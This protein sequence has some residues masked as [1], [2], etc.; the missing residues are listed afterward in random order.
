MGVFAT[1]YVMHQY[2]EWLLGTV[3]NILDDTLSVSSAGLLRGGAVAWVEVSVPESIT[4]PEGVTF[5]PNLLA[6]TSFDGSIATTFKRTVTDTV[7]DN[8]RG[9]ALAEKGQ[10]YRVKH[11]RHSR[12]RLAE[13][14]D[15]LALVHTMAED[16]AAEITTLASTSVSS[17]QWNQFLDQQ[18]LTT[19]PDGQP[20]AG[21][22][23]T[24]A[25]KKRQ[26]LHQLYRADDRVAPWAGTALGVIKAVN[27]HDHHM[28]GAR[29]TS[30]AERNMIRAVTGDIEALDRGTWDSLVRVLQAS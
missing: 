30:R 3:A 5:R 7:C 10:D 4:T 22:A 20:L 13:A 29:G 23:R 18:V 9:L 14:R 2:S 28:A 26:Q 15:A 16:F 19:G 24:L 11:S 17:I 8:T 25:D 27:T 1:G 21:R 12:M 6:T